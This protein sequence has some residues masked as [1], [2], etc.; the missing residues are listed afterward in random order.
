MVDIKSCHVISGYALIGQGLGLAPAGTACV[1]PENQLPIDWFQRSFECELV[2]R[3]IKPPPE[4]E[5]GLLDG[6]RVNEAKL[7]MQGNA[8]FVRRID[9]AD[10]DMDILCFGASDKLTHESRP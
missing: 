10:Q 7:C 2:E 4:L 8:A 1:H 3:Q 6:A 9:A 5:T